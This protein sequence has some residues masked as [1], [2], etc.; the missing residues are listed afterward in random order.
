MNNFF[1]FVLKSNVRVML[2]LVLVILSAYSFMLRSPFKDLD[3]KFSIIN[4]VEIRE[5]SNIP[6]FFTSTYFKLEQDYY[7]PMVYVTYA[8]EYRA[9]GLDYFFYNLDNVLIHVINAFLVFLI[10]GFLFNDRMRS[11]W[12]S[13]LFGIHPIHWEAVGNV[14]GRSILLCTFFVLLAFYFLLRYVRDERPGDL[15]F[16]SVSYGLA[17][18]CKESGGMFIAVAAVYW[19]TVGK[20]SPL[21]L[22][23]LWPLAL[24]A[25]GYLFVHHL[26]RISL[27]FP[28]PSWGL[29]LLGVTTFLRGVFTY[30]RLILFPV[31]LYFDRARLIYE[32]FQA[33]GVWLT[34][35]VYL[36]L[37]VLFIKNIRRIPKLAVFCGVWFWLEL[38]P[39]SQVL[40]SIG[41]Y[42]LAISLAEH[43]MYLASVPVFILLVMVSEEI[44][45]KGFISA[46]AAK[47]A[48][49]G[50]VLFFY[51][52]LVQ[53]N[54]YAGNELL[55]LQ[56]S[57]KNDPRNARVE[58]ASGSVYVRLGKFDLAVE[59]FGNAVKLYESNATYHVAL[60]KALVDNGELLQAVRV[61]E[62]TPPLKRTDKILEGNKKAAYTELVRQYEEKLVVSPKDPELLFALG[63]FNGRL[64]KTA[65]AYDAFSSA[66]GVDRTRFDALF[67]MGV[68]ADLLG[69]KGKAD[70]AFT[71]LISLA[72]PDN[73]FRQRVERRFKK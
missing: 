43:F 49:G 50:V 41:A 73:V 23:R 27:P 31:N 28:W 70:E 45:R 53:Q 21:S 2:F 68:M 15:L 36:G 1:P 13:L 39:V 58:Y 5:L 62:A 3:D 57:L 26:M 30:I 69:D 59:H 22:V 67:N 64:G 65:E 71:T 14:S 38:F 32:S 33:P 60:G 54:I 4:N 46:G 66:W 8:L 9:F 40:T 10:C 48:A 11:F 7:R 18:L 51:L 44:L 55:V 6:R 52:T 63:V 72:A 61:Y 37:L 35:G 25:A 29:M 34:L 42:P 19:V 20:K 24:V 47:L 16:L 56:N 17:L 12:V